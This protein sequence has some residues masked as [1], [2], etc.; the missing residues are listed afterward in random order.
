MIRHYYIQGE[1]GFCAAQYNDE[2]LKQ[3]RQIKLA[4][5]C[6]KTAKKHN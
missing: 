6:K 2:L 3:I 4:W 1:W 5:R